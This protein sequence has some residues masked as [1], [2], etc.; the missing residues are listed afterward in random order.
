[1]SSVV[2]SSGRYT[3]RY[4]PCPVGYHDLI[5]ASFCVHTAGRGYIRIQQATTY[6][7]DILLSPSGCC[8]SPRGFFIEA[9]FCVLSDFMNHT[10]RI[11][12]N[13]WQF[14]RL[15]SIC[16]VAWYPCFSILRNLR[17][18]SLPSRSSSVPTLTPSTAMSKWSSLSIIS[19]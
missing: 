4:S 9:L 7:V 2:T 8:R 13:R 12:T 11:I 17:T 15:V 1:M 5:K 3:I 10:L 14:F 16:A 19:Q 18:L 6:S